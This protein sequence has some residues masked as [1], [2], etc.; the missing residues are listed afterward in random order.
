[1]LVVYVYL[2]TRYLLDLVERFD[3]YSYIIAPLSSPLPPGTTRLWLIISCTTLVP[4]QGPRITKYW[5]GYGA[6]R[7]VFHVLS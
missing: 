4:T 2:A 6:P 1:M 7:L 5:V 3:G